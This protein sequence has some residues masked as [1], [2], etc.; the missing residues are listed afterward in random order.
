MP[1]QTKKPAGKSPA[2][3][4]PQ[5]DPAAVVA[6]VN[7][8]TER[9]EQVETA[10]L[11]LAKK[12][13]PVIELS[14][15]SACAVPSRGVMIDYHRRGV[16]CPA[17]IVDVNAPQHDGDIETVDLV[18]F[19]SNFGSSFRVDRVPSEAD[20][21]NPK[22]GHWEPRELPASEIPAES[23]ESDGSEATSEESEEE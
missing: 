21:K 6:A 23:D 4:S 7:A 18:V 8:L 5:L 2:G 9:V 11:E 19:G 12:D 20:P 1:E 17:V 13:E 15:I 22:R 3:S 16:V 10:L 14:A